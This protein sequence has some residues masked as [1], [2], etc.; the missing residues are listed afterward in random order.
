VKGLITGATYI[1]EHQLVVLCGYDYDKRNLLSAL[2]P[3]IVLLYDF[4]DGDL[5]SGNKRRLDFNSG[6]KAQIEGIAT[7]NGLD[8]YLSCEYF[9]TTKMGIVFEFPAQ[10]Y[11]LDLRKYLLPYIKTAGK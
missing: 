7:S 6:V 2:H 9:T 11:R 5:L 10:L 4:K 3:F 1:P 8:Y